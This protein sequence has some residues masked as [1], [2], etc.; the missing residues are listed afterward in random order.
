MLRATDETGID[1]EVGGIAERLEHVRRRG[2]KPCVDALG[3]GPDDG[4]E[5]PAEALAN[6][7]NEDKGINPLFPA[8]Q[9][10]SNT[11]S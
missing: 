3:T 8:L 4:G 7:A 10:G 1:A 2:V 9:S 5:L 6:P 11:V